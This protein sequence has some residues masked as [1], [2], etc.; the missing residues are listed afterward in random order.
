MNRKNKSGLVLLFSLFLIVLFTV[1]VNGNNLNSYPKTSALGDIDYD[2][3]NDVM[4]QNDNI[5]YSNNFNVRN[6]SSYTGHYNSTYSFENELNGTSG[7]DIDFYGSGS[8]GENFQIIDSIYNHDKVMRYFDND[9][10]CCITNFYD[11][12]VL[13]GTV[14]FWINLNDVSLINDRVYFYDEGV[15]SF[16]IRFIVNGIYDWS[17]VKFYDTSDNLWYHIKIAWFS[18]DTVDVFVNGNL[19]VNNE[20]MTNDMTNGIDSMAFIG[21]SNDDSKYTYIDAIGY[22]WDGYNATYSFIDDSDGSVPTDW[23]DISSSGCSARINNSF[24]NHY[25]ILNLYDNSGTGTAGIYTTFDTNQIDPIIEFWISSSNFHLDYTIMLREGA[26]QIV[27]L[28]ISSYD[29]EYYDSSDTLRVVSTDCFINN[30]WSHFKIVCNDSFDSFD[31]YIDSILVGNDLEYRNPV[32]NGIDGIIVQSRHS[33]DNYYY[34]FDAFG[35]SWDSF[36]NIGDNLEHYSIGD[37][38]FSLIEYNQEIKEVDKFEFAYEILYNLYDVGDDNPSTWLDIE[39]G[40]DH[41]NIAVDSGDSMDRVIKIDGIGSTHELTGIEK[42]FDDSGM[43]INVSFSINYTL[44]D[45]PNG[46]FFVKIYSNDLTE[47][48]RL[49]FL[50]KSSNT[51]YCY[52]YNGTDYIIIYNAYQKDV[53]Y[54][55]DLLINYELDLCVMYGFSFIYAE[56]IFPLMVSDKIGLGKLEFYSEATNSP[57]NNQIIYIDYVGVYSNE[58]SLSNERAFII[59]ENIK[60]FNTWY[61]TE[62]N[63][64]TIDVICENLTVNAIIYGYP[65]PTY[66]FGTFCWQKSFNGSFFWN[67][68]EYTI[69]SLPLIVNPD[70]YFAF[71]NNITINSVNIEGVKLIQDT[72]EYIPTYDYANI[73]LNETYFYVVGNELRYYLKVND[74]NLE[75]MTAT[76][77]IRDIIVY[78]KTFTYTSNRNSILP[79]EL[80]LAYTDSTTSIIDITYG[81]RVEKVSL[82]SNKELDYFQIL[83]TDNDVDFN[84]TGSGSFSEFILRGYGTYEMDIVTTN[85]LDA[86]MPLLFFIIFPSLLISYFLKQSNKDDLSEK[87]VV[88]MLM[89]FS[90]IAFASGTIPLWSLFLLIIAFGS[91]FLIISDEADS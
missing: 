83:I 8:D 33:N 75:Y 69:N 53:N 81:F 67:L 31:V 12:D 17:S 51:Y 70:L 5:N 59:L 38:R 68:Y 87:L 45:N 76:F 49:K 25:K 26:I 21:Y 10:Y 47:V 55:F 48:F 61:F 35:Y 56:M 20:T 34:Y 85:L 80:R 27:K 14:E 11:I 3:S 1:N 40:Y 43:M 82:P 66:V 58:V 36:Y 9:G 37:N 71:Y 57:G 52:Y 62:Y 19:E 24:N 72:V 77:D 74:T 88:P 44:I 79:N 65:P 22:S 50:E 32:L 18:D 78:N 4:Y 89:V 28:Y 41:T 86:I 54:T 73:E 84:K 39:N 13:N 15:A 46:E 60:G 6:S 2:F 30:V 23:F 29:L 16:Y 42:T 90:F 91:L 63:L 7:S 64:M